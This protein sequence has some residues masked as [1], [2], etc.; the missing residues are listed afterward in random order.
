M[1]PTRSPNDDVEVLDFDTGGT[2]PCLPT[3][4]DRA[5][6]QRRV[7]QQRRQRAVRRMRPYVS[8]ARR[9]ALARASRLACAG[10]AFPINFDVVLTCDGYSQTERYT[11]RDSAVMERLLADGRCVGGWS[12]MSYRCGRKKD[13]EP[14]FVHRVNVA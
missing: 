2:H 3:V 7:H 13:I 6:R 14:R 9:D 8:D 11:L 1:K 4:Q 10:A 12:G 5:D